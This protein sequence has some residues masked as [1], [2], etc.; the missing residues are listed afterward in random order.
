M[1]GE[2]ESTPAELRVIPD[3]GWPSEI[4]DHVYGAAPP[5][6]VRHA[7]TNSSRGRTRERPCTQLAASIEFETLV[8]VTL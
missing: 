4:T 6:A 8:K 3:G 5:V 1:V 2:P 7:E